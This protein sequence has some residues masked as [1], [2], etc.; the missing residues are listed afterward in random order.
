MLDTPAAA[1]HSMLQLLILCRAKDRAAQM[2][3]AW[4]LV[5]VQ[6]VYSV[7]MTLPLTLAVDN[8]AEARTQADLI[9][10]GS[11]AS[12]GLS[13]ALAAGL[14]AGESSAPRAFHH[15]IS[16]TAMMQQH[17][18]HMPQLSVGHWGGFS[19][20]RMLH[21]FLAQADSMW[22]VSVRWV[23]YACNQ[24]QQHSSTQHVMQH[25]VHHTAIY[26]YHVIAQPLY[27]Q[28]IQAVH[29]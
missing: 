25:Y 17:I 15:Y 13:S 21:W 6:Q 5:Q 16:L 1:S 24:Q 29:E 12:S 20:L 11:N 19:P 23:C 9:T 27:G 22:A 7:A 4:R 10:T 28:C 8:L 14:I 3:S 18:H 26:P 2:A